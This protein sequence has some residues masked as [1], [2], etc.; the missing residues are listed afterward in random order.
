MIIRCVDV[1]AH[2]T[3]SYNLL[4]NLAAVIVQDAFPDIS[5]YKLCKM[6]RYSSILAVPAT[7]FIAPLASSKETFKVRWFSAF[8]DE[9]E[10][11]GHGALASA[12]VLH[13]LGYIDD[14]LVLQT[15]KTELSLY[16]ETSA[17]D[18]KTSWILSLP[19]IEGLK[20]I[21]NERFSTVLGA[22]PEEIYAT[23][24]PDGYCVLRFNHEDSIHSLNPDFQA[25]KSISSRAVIATALSN[26]KHY[27]V[28]QRYFAPAFG[29]NEDIATGSAAAV[30]APFWQAVHDISSYRVR[31]CSNAGG[32]MRVEL[33]GNRVLLS[34]SAAIS[35]QKTTFYQ[36]HLEAELL[37]SE[38]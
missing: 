30:L 25:L 15:K 17:S 18:A 7:A 24:R 6:R 33:A 2:Q 35:E 36:S 10:L 9:I 5:Q 34:G 38:R 13:S 22:E 16:K 11:C 12:Q 26:N 1:F 23:D 3:E 27:D 29:V 20:K 32:W 37:S 8:G 28:V 14:K 21:G 31:Q 19:K 4:G